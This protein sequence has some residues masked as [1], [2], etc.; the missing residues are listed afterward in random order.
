MTELERAS[1]FLGTFKS[2]LGLSDEVDANQ[3]SRT[4]CG[5]VEHSEFKIACT[6]GVYF[7]TFLTLLEK[8]EISGNQL[9]EVP[10][11]AEE[12]I[13]EWGTATMVEIHKCGSKPG[14]F[15]SSIGAVPRKGT[16]T[17]RQ[18]EA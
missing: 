4:G 10:I 8:H 16:V 17:V 1:V 13:Q 7:E 12:A 15:C 3:N 9:R 11:K 6:G 2:T 18:R 5:R 14:I